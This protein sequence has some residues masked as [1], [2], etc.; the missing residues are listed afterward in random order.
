MPAVV[1]SLADSSTEEEFHRR[2]EALDN[3]GIWTAH[4][5]LSAYIYHQ[6]V[7]DDK[8]KV[9]ARSRSA[10]LQFNDSSCERRSLCY[11]EIT[12][13]RLACYS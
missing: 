8:Y 12:N 2:W 7:K 6:W 9:C 1:Q 5:N 11:R 3:D 4:P 13:A 10:L